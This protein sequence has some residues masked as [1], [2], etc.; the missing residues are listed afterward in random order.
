MLLPLQQQ[1]QPHRW[2]CSRCSCDSCSLR[3][4]GCA[5]G[6]QDCARPVTDRVL[7][8]VSAVKD[9]AL[10]VLCNTE[11]CK[12]HSTLDCATHSHKVHAGCGKPGLYRASFKQAAMLGCIACTW[13]AWDGCSAVQMCG[14]GQVGQARTGSQVG[15]DGRAATVDGMTGTYIVPIGAQPDVGLS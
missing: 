15:Q 2:G 8:S 12:T 10:T 3:T 5:S 4:P 13:A 9:E 6:K 7:Q 14:P 1:T 11:P